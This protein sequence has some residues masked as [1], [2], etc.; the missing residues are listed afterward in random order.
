MSESGNND[1]FERMVDRV[2]SYRPK[3]A[4]RKKKGNAKPTRKA[5]RSRSHGEE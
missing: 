4:K 2:L 3:K 5:P 1:L